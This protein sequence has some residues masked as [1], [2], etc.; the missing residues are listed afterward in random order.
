VRTFGAFLLAAV[1]AFPCGCRRAPT[2]KKQEVAVAAAANLTEVLAEIGT[3][4]EAQTGIHPVF[5]FGSTA[6]LAI[7]IEHGA[8]FDVF[9]AADAEHITR[10]DQKGLLA[11]GTAAVYARG[12]LALWIPPGASVHLSR[13]EDVA[14]PEVRVIAV[15]KP[16]L[17]PYGRATVETLERAGVWD[18]VKSKVV[19]AE[20]I[21]MARQFGLS[22][23]ADVVFTA[24][25]LVLHEGGT[26][27]RVDESLHTPIEQR[28][29]VLQRSPRQAE[30]RRFTDF[31]LGPAGRATLGRYG[32]LTPVR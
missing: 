22:R 5:S 4:F 16:E 18:R 10:L 1:L 8:P 3:A 7:Q 28:L 15:A 20:N 12:A 23:N 11:P 9:A 19:Y 14:L 32:Y 6:Q 30:A 25:S 17:A 24:Y 27:L 21:S 31:L 26:L 29:G 2:G 13:V